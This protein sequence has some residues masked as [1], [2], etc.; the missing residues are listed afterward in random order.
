MSKAKK[1]MV[2]D[3]CMTVLLVFEM[4]YQ[5]TGNALHEYVGFA[6]FG[7]IVVHLILSRKWISSTV[8][9]LGTKELNSRRKM[10]ALIAFLLAVDIVLL[11]VSSVM[12]S[13]TFWEMGLDFSMFN[14]GDIWA[15]IHTATSYAL[16][17]IVAG[18]L[19]SHWTFLAKSMH[20]EYNPAR[21]QAIGQAVNVAAGMGALALGVAGYSHVTQAIADEQ[22]AQRELQ[23]ASGANTSGGSPGAA[24]EEGAGQASSAGGVQNAQID[25]RGAIQQDQNAQAPYSGH[26]GRARGSKNGKGKANAEQGTDQSAT[27]PSQQNTEG[28]S[29]EQGWQ[30]AVPGVS[31]GEGTESS[32]DGICTLCRKQCSFSNLRCDKPYRE[33]L[34]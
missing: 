2:L 20:I 19:A 30:E 29:E 17:I 34:L 3:V 11:G 8:S 15:P 7:C 18:H 16:C 33:G 1:R 24:G 25:D 26:G 14:P 9:S 28:S 22:L 12:I 10:L 31:N 27:Q 23:S 5:L 32:N 21:R 6:F 13:N 4:F